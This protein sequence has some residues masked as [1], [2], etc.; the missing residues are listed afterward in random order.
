MRL[1]TRVLLLDSLAELREERRRRRKHGGGAAATVVPS[2]PTTYGSDSFNRSDRSLNGDAADVGGNWSALVGTWNVISNQCGATVAGGLILLKL[3]TGQADGV[4]R[5][6]LAHL[7]TDGM[8]LAARII[9]SANCL[10]MR[11]TGFSITLFRRTG[12]GNTS[13][14]SAVCSETDGDTNKLVM[15]GSTLDCYLNDVLQFSVTETQGQTTTNQGVLGSDID[16]R[17]DDWSHKSA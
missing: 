12:G 15:T 1:L 7:G 6:T 8:A 3:A 17:I 4:L 9:D 11:Q 16:S 14:G 2:G 13:I 10:W 5:Q